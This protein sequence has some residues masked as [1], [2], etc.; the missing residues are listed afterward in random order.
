[1]ANYPTYVAAAPVAIYTYLV[2]AMLLEVSPRAE[3][4]FSSR[5]TDGDGRADEVKEFIKDITTPRGLLWDNDRL[6][7]LHPPH[8][9]AFHDKDGDGISESN[10]RLVSDIAFGYP[11]RNGDHTTNGLDIGP[12]GWI[13]VFR[14]SAS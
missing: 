7:L 13:Y 10:E 1:M 12:D 6:Y 5:D 14:T 3:D 9:T 8:I 2:M 4:V 11:E